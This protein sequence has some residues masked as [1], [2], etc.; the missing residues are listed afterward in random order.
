MNTVAKIGYGI[1]VVDQDGNRI[2]KVRNVRINS[3]VTDIVSATVW[4]FVA[5]KNPRNVTGGV[6]M[7][8]GRAVFRKGTFPV[9]GIDAQGDGLTVTVDTSE[10]TSITTDPADDYETVGWDA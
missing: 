2:P 8:G 10:E 3:H 1:N 7:R 9:I 6:L 4:A 5:D